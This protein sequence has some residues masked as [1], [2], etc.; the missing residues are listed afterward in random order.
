ML[1]KKKHVGVL[2]HTLWCNSLG[3]V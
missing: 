3:F 2:S 1:I